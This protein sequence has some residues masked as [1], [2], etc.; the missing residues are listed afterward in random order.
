[1]FT[2]SKK[3]YDENV[4]LYKEKLELREYDFD[5]DDSISVPFHY[6]FIGG[7]YFTS[8]VENSNFIGVCSIV[9]YDTKKKMIVD[10]VVIKDEIVFDNSSGEYDGVNETLLFRMAIHKLYIEPDVYIFEDDDIFED[11]PITV[12]EYLCMDV[13]FDGIQISKIKKSVK[14]SKYNKEGVKNLSKK[15]PEF[16]KVF[17]GDM[18]TGAFVPK[19]DL[20]VK[21][22]NLK[23]VE[24]LHTLFAFNLLD[25]TGYPMI[26]NEAKELIKEDFND[27]IHMSF[28]K[29]VCLKVLTDTDCSSYN[30]FV[31]FLYENKFFDNLKKT[32]IYGIIEEHSLE[33]MKINNFYVSFK[34][35]KETTKNKRE[36]HIGISDSSGKKIYDKLSFPMKEEDLLE[37]KE[38]YSKVFVKNSKEYKEFVRDLK[39]KG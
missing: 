3:V 35:N 32:Y 18:F 30:D 16:L 14:T 33:D 10:K 11:K 1:M 17:S 13:Y 21:P 24:A 26:L 6:S 20:Y 36:I 39:K 9:V 29:D 19:Y 5:E 27:K 38:I 28:I 31:N 15:V 4:K 22:I 37:N 7:V 2:L 8:Y 25:D 23:I 34:D 12:P